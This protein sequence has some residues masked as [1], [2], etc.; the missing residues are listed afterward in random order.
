VIDGEA[1]VR[2][3]S[4]VVESTG[5]IQRV[6][7]GSEEKCRCAPSPPTRLLQ[8]SMD[9]MRAQRPLESVKQNEQRRSCFTIEV[10]KIKK[11]TVRCVETFEPKAEW[12]PGAHEFPPERL[13]VRP[14]KPPGRRKGLL[15]QEML[16]DI[17]SNLFTTK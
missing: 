11:I 6:S 3:L 2:G 12:Q 7:A 9:I 8:Q 5:S 16:D 13:Q 15:R 14:W 1:H 17:Q 10:I 4:G